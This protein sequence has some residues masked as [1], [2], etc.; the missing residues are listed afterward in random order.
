MSDLLLRCNNI[1]YCE[2]VECD[3]STALF[4]QCRCLMLPSGKEKNTSS[5]AE[6]WLC[7]NLLSVTIRQEGQLTSARVHDFK[8]VDGTC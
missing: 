6:Q 1:G 8:K 7:S 3:L 2:Y 5:I 4:V